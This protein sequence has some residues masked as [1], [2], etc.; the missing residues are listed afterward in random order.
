MHVVGMRQAFA[1]NP[2]IA[3]VKS[4]DTILVSPERGLEVITRP[5]RSSWPLLRAEV[6]GLGALDRPDILAL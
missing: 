1:W 6:E 4:E 2:S 3:G 5:E